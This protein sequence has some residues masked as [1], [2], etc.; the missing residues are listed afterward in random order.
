MNDNR[1]RKL[2]SIVFDFDG[3]LA[4][5][6]IDFGEMKRRMAVLA[7]EHV[8]V[9]LNSSLPPVLEWLESLAA[10][11]EGANPRAAAD[12][13]RRAD[14][15]IVEMELEAA[16]RGRLFDFTRPVLSRLRSKQIHVAIITRNCEEAVRIAFPDL[17][18]Y[19]GVFLARGHVPKV[20][21][22]PDHLYRALAKVAWEPHSTLM[23]GDHPLDIQT[24]KRAGVLT[25][26]VSSG[27]A[28][29]DDLI[30]SGADWTAGNCE[31][32]MRRLEEEGWV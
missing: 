14:A 10:H 20:K 22:D 29:L 4:E 3:T 30:R 5:L 21:P 16:R 25:A 27:R 15:L 6:H 13:R 7:R 2:R 8:P 11:L 28:S 31:E 23:V 18:G 19:C 26:G 12:F 32:L 9:E 24:G 17:D 1:H